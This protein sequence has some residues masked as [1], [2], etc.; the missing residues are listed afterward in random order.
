MKRLFIWI[1]FV[2]VVCGKTAFA[3]SFVHPGGLH[4][5]ADLERMRTNVLAG[6]HP[7]IDGWQQLLR[8]PHPGTIFMDELSDVTPGDRE[9]ITPP[10]GL[11]VWAVTNRW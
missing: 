6:N 8:D 9:T 10:A 3:T 11:A 2:A 4:T 5:L 7:W 1:A